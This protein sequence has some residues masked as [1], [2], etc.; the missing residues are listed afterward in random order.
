MRFFVKSFAE[1]RSSYADVDFLIVYITEA[2]AV[3]EWPIRSG[4]YHGGEPVHVRQP[5]RLA[6]RIEVAKTF[7]ARYGL[8][9]D[10]PTL[11]D[12]PEDGDPFCAAFCPWPIRFY[13]VQHGKMSHIAMPNH[14]EYS[15][16][17][18]REALRSGSN[19]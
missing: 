18:V 12:S 6:D 5:K 15:L 16:C 4:R 3:D 14:A 9:G 19:G 13:V 8:L 7:L 10:L 17:K 11:V 1:L 2:H